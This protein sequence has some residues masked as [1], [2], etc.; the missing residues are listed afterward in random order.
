MPNPEHEHLITVGELKKR[1]EDLSD[2]TKIYFGCDKL[3]FY[4]TKR[5]GDKLLQI[6]FNQPVWSDEEGNIYVDKI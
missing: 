5:R 2:D 1:L 4:R 3:E 6:E